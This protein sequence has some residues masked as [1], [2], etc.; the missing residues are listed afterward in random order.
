MVTHVYK[1]PTVQRP[2]DVFDGHGHLLGI[3]DGFRPDATAGGLGLEVEFVEEARSLLDTGRTRVWISADR[4]D[5]VRKDRVILDVT[6]RE[7]RLELRDRDL[8][9][10][11]PLSAEKD[12]VQPA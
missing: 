2:R 5:R 10:T 7:L 12:L 11:R 6:L 8:W 4:V 9:S 1:A 3:S